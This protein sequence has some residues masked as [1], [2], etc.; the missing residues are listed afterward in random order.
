MHLGLETSV[1]VDLN[2]QDMK[3]VD[4]LLLVSDVKFGTLRAVTQKILIEGGVNPHIRTDLAKPVRL[5]PFCTPRPK[6]Y[7]G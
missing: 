6:N 2:I 3:N 5:V 1:N 4:L 7:S